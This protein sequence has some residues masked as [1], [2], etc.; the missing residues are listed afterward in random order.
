[1]IW[2]I[3]TPVIMVLFIIASNRLMYGDD[4]LCVDCALVASVICAIV[5]GAAS[6]TMLLVVCIENT[7]HDRNLA[8][9]QAK[10]AALEYQ[11]DSGIYFGDAVGEFNSELIHNQ[12]IHNDPWT[13]W[14]AGKY[15]MEVDP[16]ELK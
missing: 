16:V 11:I 14:F 10:R 9:L 8:E 15:W 5:A 7:H 13:S 1:M 2:T 12:Y 6:F 4:F 3:I